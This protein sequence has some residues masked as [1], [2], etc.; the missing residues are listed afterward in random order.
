MEFHSRVH[1]SAGL[2]NFMMQI[3]T[4]SGEHPCQWEEGFSV[5][6]NGVDKCKLQ[7]ARCVE[8]AARLEHRVVY[9]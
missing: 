5:T 6:F 1:S 7:P 8:P 9:S 4:T 2:F 3:H